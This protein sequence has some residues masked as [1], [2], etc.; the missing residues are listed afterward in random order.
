MSS[1]TASRIFLAVVILFTAVQW[2]T[3]VVPRTIGPKLAGESRAFLDFDCYA[4]AAERARAGLP[5]FGNDPGDLPEYVY[6]P[7]LAIG[8][9]PLT[10]VS[11]DTAEWIWLGLN[12]AAF[13]GIVPLLVAAFRLPRGPT[14]VALAILLVGAPMAT[15]ENLALGQVNG[16]LFAL[17]LAA[18]VG[19]DR[20]RALGPA[21]LLAVA[22]V[23]KMVPATLILEFARRRAWRAAG[24][25]ALLGALLLAASFVAA[26]ADSPADFLHAVGSKSTRDLATSNNASLVAG[27]FRA[28][29]PAPAAARALVLANAFL[30]LAVA[31]WAVREARRRA[32]ARWFTA[33]AFALVVA[34]APVL[35]AHHLVFLVPGFLLLALAARPSTRPAGAAARIAGVVALAALVNSRGLVPPDAGAGQ[36][37]ALLVKPA[38]V[39]LWGVIGWLAWE[40]R[41]GR[42]LPVGRPTAPN[43]E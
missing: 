6:P 30:A 12:L 5:I 9:V 42:E 17:L 40:L 11:H 1:R 37:W 3:R 35:E 36:P 15:L 34:P 13:L 33:L 25:A 22:A 2:T 29:D 39:G 7:L 27:L 43:Q 16:M 8:L 31:A 28:I 10:F 4:A 14:P 21:A 20:G 24:A 23:T 38:G 18:I 26:P 19:L 41:R 32:E